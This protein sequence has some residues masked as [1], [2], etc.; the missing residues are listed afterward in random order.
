MPPVPNVAL[1]SPGR[2]QPWPTSDACWSPAMPQMGGAPASAA[3]LAHH[4]DEST[5]VGSTLAG[6]RSASSMVSSQS[7][8]SPVQ[9][10][11]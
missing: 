7:E 9:Q 11:R 8:P 2:V 6:M 3:R 5:M 1:A 10:A 4:P